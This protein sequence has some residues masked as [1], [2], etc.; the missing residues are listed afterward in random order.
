MRFVSDL[1]MLRILK[2][3]GWV[4]SKGVVYKT[5]NLKIFIDPENENNKYFLHSAYKECVSRSGYKQFDLFGA[6]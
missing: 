6:K 4:E 1:E 2:K 5:M 3:N